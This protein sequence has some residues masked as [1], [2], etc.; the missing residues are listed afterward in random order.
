MPSVRH[1]RLRFRGS[2]PGG[3]SAGWGH[4]ARLSLRAW[5]AL[6]QER[7]GE[8]RYLTGTH[9]GWAMPKSPAGIVK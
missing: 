1:E 5:V 3:M 2:L 6:P 4:R 7:H 8:G 9:H